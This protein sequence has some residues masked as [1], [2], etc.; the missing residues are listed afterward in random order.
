MPAVSA[1][2]PAPVIAEPKNTG[3]TSARPVCAASSPR[4]RPVRDG[5]RVVDVRGQERVVVLGEQ[6]GE[7]G[8]ERGVG[9]P[10]G[11]KDALARAEVA[12]RAHRDDRRRQL[13]GDRAEHAVV[14]RAARGRSC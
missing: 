5:C 4:S 10:Y 8:R 6:L 11:A 1:S 3:C 2:T 12:H 14:R 7:L 9:A 13:L